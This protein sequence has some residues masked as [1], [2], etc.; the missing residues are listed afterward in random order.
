VERYRLDRLDFV[1]MDIEGAELEAMSAA[2]ETRARFKPRYAI[3]SYHPL[4]GG[5]L[6]MSFPACLP[7]WDTTARP[8][9]QGI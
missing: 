7:S 3:A 1:K 6:P 5:K 2:G 9:I 4:D 8:A